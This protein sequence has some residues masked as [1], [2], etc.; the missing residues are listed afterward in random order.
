MHLHA[1]QSHIHPR[2]TLVG[3]SGFKQRN[4]AGFSYLNL[5][6]TV[7]GVER[8]SA[9]LNS[10]FR[11]SRSPNYLIEAKNSFKLKRNCSNFADLD[12]PATAVGL[13]WMR[14]DQLLWTCILEAADLQLDSWRTTTTSNW[15]K[16][17][18]PNCET[19][20]IQI[21]PRLQ[22]VCSEEEVISPSELAFWKQQTPNSYFPAASWQLNPAPNWTKFLKQKFRWFSQ[23]KAARSC[24][25]FARVDMWSLSM[26][27]HFRCIRFP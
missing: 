10:H 16:Y 25:G 6:M 20:R 7:V 26:N 8:W 5:P 14:G 21:C 1:K 19:A 3:A 11:S 27:M 15:I 23:F 24:Q 12:P 18:K 13:R 9:P 4:C 17:L 2:E 22:W